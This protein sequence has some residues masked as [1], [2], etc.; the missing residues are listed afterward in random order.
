[1]IT[2]DE[3]APLSASSETWTE[4]L[5]STTLTA[6]AAWTT[7]TSTDVASQE[8]R[9]YTNVTCSVETSP[10][11]AETGLAANVSTRTVN[12]A[13]TGTY[14]YQIRTIDNAGLFTDSSCSPAILIDTSPP[15][16]ATNLAWTEGAFA[17]TS[18]VNVTWDVGGSADTATQTLTVHNDA[19]CSTAAVVTHSSLGTSVSSH[20]VT[21]PSEGSFYLK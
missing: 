21:L 15:N 4:G 2:V 6:N 20:A 8:I 3:T 5:F 14:Y 18:S 7:S 1:M 11:L 16:P 17:P 10:S 9:Y 12:F 13:A 19:A